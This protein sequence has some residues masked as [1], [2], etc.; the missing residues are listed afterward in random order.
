MTTQ[1]TQIRGKVIGN[2]T[3]PDTGV[4]SGVGTDRFAWGRGGIFGGE[5][6]V[7]SFLGESFDAALPL[8]FALSP[9]AIEIK[10][11]GYT[12]G[13][14]QKNRSD[15]FS[16]GK[17]SYFN[18]SIS[19][20][21]EA[22]RVQLDITIEAI[23]P[24]E[25]E[26]ETFSYQLYL[27]NTSNND[28]PQ[29]SADYVKFQKNLAPVVIK[30]SNG[31]PLTLNIEGF[32]SIE[33]G[34]FSNKI[35]E[36]SV[37]EG[38]FAEADLVGRFE[39]PIESIVQSAVQVGGPGTD[40]SIAIFD[41]LG[42]DTFLDNQIIAAFTPQFG[43]TVD[44]AAKLC[45]YDHFN[46]YQIVT[47][48]PNPPTAK[49]SDTPLTTPYVDPPLGGYKNG[50]P[51]GTDDHLPFFWNDP[52]S[53]GEK[54]TRQNLEYN[55]S[56]DRKTLTFIDTPKLFSGQPL[57]P[58]KY[59]NFQ[60]SLV[61]VFPDGTFQVL[62]TFTWKSNYNGEDGG[63][64]DVNKG[65]V[66]ERFLANSNDRGG[67]FD[68][69]LNLNPADISGEVRQR[70][71]ADGARNASGAAA[72]PPVSIE[73][74]GEN[75]GHKLK[76]K[77]LSENFQG[78]SKN[79]FINAKGGNDR[80]FG[81]KGD[82]YLKGGS[83]KDKLIGDAGNDVLV[84]GAERDTLTGGKGRDLFV[85][86]YLN[87][88]VDKIVDFSRRSDLIDLTKVFTSSIFAD[89]DIFSRF[90]EFLQVVSVG[91]NTQ[92]RIDADGAGEGTVFTPL[93][94]LKNVAASSINTKSFVIG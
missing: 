42:L 75:Q 10:P 78:T 5:P 56:P 35:D 82:D 6:S 33:G 67:I 18:G 57:Q 65:E 93:V 89:V 41:F 84:G 25:T 53:D 12:Y 70:M 7:L 91:S 13:Q 66:R 11:T 80:I 4:T 47:N 50:K 55:T 77:S 23:S 71:A 20:G 92:I 19:P 54:G 8:G 38:N 36:F 1:T 73:F 68:L 46:W 49:G 34:G 44:E 64:D 22:N 88:G 14:R 72:T 63:V 69:K 87:D 3:N 60:T 81:N 40:I 21:T 62:Y 43:L 16:L 90:T 39:D 29:A 94:T 85:F 61:G 58:G 30:T 15:T 51:P 17:L 9:N 79:D 74:N 59:V 31:A 45:G 52:L 76:G 28:D 32:G 2:F 83:G 48:D 37:L 86:N 27:L 26:P 24:V